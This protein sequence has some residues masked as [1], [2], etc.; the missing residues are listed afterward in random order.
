MAA[1]IAVDLGATSGRVILV[2]FDEGIDLTEVHRFD[3]SAEQGPDGLRLDIAQLLEDIQ[4]G[5]AWAMAMA[6]D[7]VRAVGI[8]SWA[9]DYGLVAGGRLV[10]APFH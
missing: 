2:R 10:D 1:V 9:V 8:D 6:P 5:I 4:E 3:T 7:G